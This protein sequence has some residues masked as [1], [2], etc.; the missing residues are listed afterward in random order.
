MRHKSLRQLA[1]EMG[2]SASYLSQVRNGEKR[3]SNKVAKMLTSSV[4]Q[5]VQNVNQFPFSVANTADESR[6]ASRTSTPSG[7]INSVFGGFDSHALPPVRIYR[8]LLL[9]IRWRMAAGR[10]ISPESSTGTA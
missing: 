5:N 9:S 1:R 10:K 3:M 7:G 4:N 8:R 6:W 2:V